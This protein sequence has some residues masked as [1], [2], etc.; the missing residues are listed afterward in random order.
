MESKLT[1]KWYIYSNEIHSEERYCHNCGSKVIFQ[2]SLKRRQNANG[3]NIFYFAI[4]KCPK[5]HTWNK[6][7]D[8]FKAISGLVNQ[9][10]EHAHKENEY[11][12][13]NIRR[14]KEDGIEEIEILLEVMEDS[15]RIDKFLL[16]D[17]RNILNDAEKISHEIACDKALT[18]FEKYRI[19]QDK[20]YKSDF[21]L[22]L[23]ESK[24]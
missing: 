10:E 5:G 16:S 17:D 19:K 8:K 6:S 24:K 9:P 11:E 23:E 3:K 13:L 1:L 14:L 2:D 18:E 21:D 7:I 4:Y 15:A 12:K 22:L 20:L